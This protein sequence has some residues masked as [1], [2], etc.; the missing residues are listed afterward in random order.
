LNEARNR[1][2][3]SQIL[4]DL[5]GELDVP[6]SKYEEAKEHYQ[7]VGDWLGEEDSELAPFDPQIY[8]Q[9]SFA[10]GTAVRPLGDDE[11]DVD[12][13][14]LLKLTTDQVTQKQLKE[15]V[16]RRL[17]HPSS[18]YKNKI[19]PAEGG[20]RCWT[21][22]YA[23]ESRFHLDILPC[24]L[25]DSRELAG[26]GTP[27]AIAEHAIR[28]TDKTTPEY[29]TGWPENGSDPTRSNPKGYAM[30][31]RDRMRVR[32]AEAK[33]ARA[34][35]KR[36]SVEEIE[37]YQVRTPLQRAV[38]ILKRHRD[39]RYNGDNDK[40]ISIVITTLAAKAYDN[41]ADLYEAI[42][43]IV[44]G[45]RSHIEQ[46]NGVWWIANPV[47]PLENF[48]DKWEARPRK[49]ELFFE[50]LDAL[51]AEYQNMVTDAGLEKVGTYLTESYGQRDA[52]AAMTKYASRQVGQSGSVP[53]ATIILV[54]RR[55][56]SDEPTYSNIKVAQP[57]KPW[58]E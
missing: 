51:E 17:K 2:Q 3:A 55:S 46:R 32:L 9:G 13:V 6:P 34:M 48:A 37:D 36:A 21:I 53:G 39:V 31:F 7:A 29:D 45:M 25:D 50:W 33:A 24:V 20:C 44:S 42:M 30:W 10:F 43:N 16:G 15:L 54:P 26:I 1:K 35:E 5:S 56:D 8:V 14:C 49:A 38:Q 57:S 4:R 19:E 40:P 11:Y 28:L 58:N 27:P 52:M 47:N 18:R 22:Q 41:E 12:A 23:D